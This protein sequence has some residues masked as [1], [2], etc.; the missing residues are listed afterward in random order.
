MPRTTVDNQNGMIVINWLLAGDVTIQYQVH[1]DLIDSDQTTVKKLQERIASEGWGARYLAL[2]NANGHWGRGYYQ[3]K[4]TSTHYTL[5]D[6]KN[7]GLPAA[8]LQAR[9]SVFMILDHCHEQD[10]GINYFPQHQV[11]DVCLGGMVLD[12][13][14]WFQPGHPTL[15][16]II[17]FLLNTQM[18]DGGWNCRHLHGAIHSSL[19]TTL[20]V[21]EGFLEYRRSG[22]KY[23]LDH[24]SEVEQQGVEFILKHRLFQSHRTSKTINPQFLLL[25]YPCRWHYDILRALD[26]FQKAGIGY[27]SRMQPALD[28]LLKKRRKD[29]TWPVQNKHPGQVHFELEKIGAPSRWNTLRALRVLRHFQ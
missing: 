1:R 15:D 19:H 9:A 23:K 25:S 27:D 24:I 11:S 2:Q 29:S 17:D 4:W 21:L 28:I 12:F 22:G 20:S 6:L 10:G 8:N 5:Q 26:Y 18:A 3:P 7:L 14:A 16:S 13:G